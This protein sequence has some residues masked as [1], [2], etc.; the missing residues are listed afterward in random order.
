MNTSA[1][2]YA[3]LMSTLNLTPEGLINYISIEQIQSADSVVVAMEAPA[4]FSYNVTGQ[5]NNNNNNGGS[6][7]GSGTTGGGMVSTTG[8]GF[9]TT[10]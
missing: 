4:K 10:A 7:T 6:T 9:G 2:V 3:E 1:I 8:D 5:D